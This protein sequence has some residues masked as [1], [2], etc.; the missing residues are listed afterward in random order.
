MLPPSDRPLRTVVRSTRCS[1]LESTRAKHGTLLVVLS[2]YG[3]VANVFLERFWTRRWRKEEL[4]KENLVVPGTWLSARLRKVAAREAI[5]M[6][7]AARERDG[8]WAKRPIHRG[9]RMHLSSTIASLRPAT[10]ARHFDAWLHLASIGRGIVLDLPIRF[11]RHY[12]RFAQDPRARRRESY[13]VTRDSVQLAFEVET[14][15]PREEGPRFGV[16]SGV[17]ALATLSDG[18][19]FGRDVRPLLA[20]IDR[21][22]HGSRGQQRARRALRQRMAEVASLDPQLVVVEDLKRLHEGTRRDRRLSKRMRRSLGA[23]TYREWLGRLARACETNRVRF[24]RVPPAYTSQRCHV[25]GHTEKGSRKGEGFRCRGCGYSGNAD[26]NAARNLLYRFKERELHP[27]G[28][29][30]PDFQRCGMR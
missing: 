17:N 26:E 24:E 10:E 4:T 19:S 20:R 5:D 29:Y 30:G 12:H 6:V 21:C 1:L 14:D 15:S 28:A 9:T 18:R 16:D 7:R 3:R 27:A 25:G 13:I 11:H 2:E 22:R 8:R 23:W